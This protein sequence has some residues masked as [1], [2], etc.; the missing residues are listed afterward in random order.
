VTIYG[1]DFLDSERLDEIMGRIEEMM[2]RDANIV[3]LSE[4]D[5]GISA[6][7]VG[8]EVLLSGLN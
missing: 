3:F 7:D 2:D 8:Y 5:D 1:N 4:V 6:G